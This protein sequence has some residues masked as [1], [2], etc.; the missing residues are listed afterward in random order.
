MDPAKVSAIP[1]WPIP[2]NVKE[3]QS[4]LGFSNLYRTFIHNYSSLASPLTSLTR[5][6]TRFCWTP[7]AEGAFTSLQQAFITA[8][9][10]QH[11]EPTKPVTIEADA[12]DYALG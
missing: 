6:T 1:D 8:P 5:K 10:L 12:S 11:F 7:Q 9:I 3:V 2:N 4:Y